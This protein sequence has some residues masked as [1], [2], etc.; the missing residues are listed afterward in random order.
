MRSNCCD[1]VDG[2]LFHLYFSKT[3]FF[4]SFLFYLQVNGSGLFELRL[5][6]F[7]NDYGKNTDGLCCSGQSDSITQQCIGT[8][9][10]RF[11]VCL[12]H[13]QANIDTSSPC[14]FGDVSTSV[15]GENSMNLTALGLQQHPGFVNPIRFPFHFTWPVSHCTF[16]CNFCALFFFFLFP[17]HFCF[18]S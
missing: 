16:H 18:H 14:T 15:V 4:F 13:Y 7:K 6:Y 12:K 8:C 11:R 2:L 1:K 3:N 9:K 10:T 17:R 5:K